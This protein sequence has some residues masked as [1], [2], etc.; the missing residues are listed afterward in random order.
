MAMDSVHFRFGVFVGER[1][2]G[3]GREQPRVLGNEVDLLASGNQPVRNAACR[4]FHVMHGA[5]VANALE[6][7]VGHAIGI[8]VRVDEIV[9]RATA[10][11]V[12][13]GKLQGY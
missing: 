10:H 4:V 6:L 7:L 5:V 3:F 2:A 9:K 11:K 13:S 1:R 8:D 12:G